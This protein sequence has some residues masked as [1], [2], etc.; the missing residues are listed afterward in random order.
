MTSRD[1][2]QGAFLEQEAKRPRYG[3][4]RHEVIW[5]KAGLLGMTEQETRVTER[6][7]AV[8]RSGDWGLG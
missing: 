3:D 2:E 8:E 7:V 6:K 1:L 4:E 5:Q